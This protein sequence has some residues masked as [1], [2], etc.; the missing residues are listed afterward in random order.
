MTDETFNLKSRMDKMSA[1]WTEEQWQ[2]F[3]SYAM[4]ESEDAPT[5]SRVVT[6]ALPTL[7]TENDSLK[8]R[9]AAAEVIIRDHLTPDDAPA[10]FI[11]VPTQAIGRALLRT[12]NPDALEQP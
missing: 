11:G 4:P 9:I 5:F 8:A 12:L 7:I 10:R 6:A 2:R 1:N 3:Y